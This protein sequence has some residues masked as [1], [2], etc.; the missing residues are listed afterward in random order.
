MTKDSPKFSVGLAVRNGRHSVGRCIESILSQDFTDF[1]LVISDNASDDG[2]RRMLEEYGCADPRLRINVNQTNIGLHENMRRALDLSRGT[3]FRWIS[4]DDWLEPSYLSTCVR[5]LESRPDA[6]GV[7]T[8]F[9]I[10][11][12]GRPPR[13]EEYRGDVPDSPDPAQRFERMLWFL[14]AGDAKYDPVYGVYRRDRLI[15]TRFPHPSERTDWLISAELALLGPVIHVQERLANR[16]R[17]YPRG[18][19]Q[20][21]FRRRLDPVL[22]EQLRTNPLRLCRELYALAVSAD[23]SNAQLRRCRSALRR[24]WIKEQIRL[25]RSGISETRHRILRR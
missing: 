7:T 5:A 8:W 22:A 17:E 21:A 9:T 1:E 6:T 19:D 24:F 10:H 13:Y 4:A 2:T 25:A 14:H 20:V 3:F 23:L 12:P 18:V 16:T 11:T 15:R